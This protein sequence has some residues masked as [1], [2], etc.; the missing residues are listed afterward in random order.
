MSI[1]EQF[2][3]MLEVVNDE[4]ISE[5]EHEL[6]YIKLQSWKDGVRAACRYFG[7]RE[8]E[9]NGDYHYMDLGIGRPMCCGA[10]LDW[11]HK[12]KE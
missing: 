12:P 2:I 3:A 9:L 1:Y 8:P 11:K 7:R 10:F 6:A 5:I 4:T